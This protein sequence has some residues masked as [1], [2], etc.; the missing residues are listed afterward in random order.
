MLPED[1]ATLLCGEGDERL[2]QQEFP[3]ATAFYLAAFSCCGPTAV[4]RVSSMARGLWEQVVATLEAWCKGK[5]QIPKIQ[6]R[7]LAVVSLSVGI[8]AIFLS[9]LIPNNVVALVYKLEALLQRGC[10]E[11]VVS[12]CNLLLEANPRG[13]MELLLLRALA[14]VLSGTQVG[15]GIMDYVQA[16]VLHQT[17]AVAYVYD[18]QREHLPQVIQA[19]SDHLSTCQEESPG[20]RSSEQWLGDCYSFLAAVAPGHTWVCR[21][22]AAHLLK[23]GEFQECVTVCTKA[24]EGFSA[25]NLRGEDVLVLHLERAAGYFFLGGWMQEMMQD[26]A[27]AFAADPARAMKCFEE[28]FSPCEVEKIE[29][30]ARAALEGKFAAYRKAVRARAELRGSHGTELLPPV[31]QTIQLL[32]HICPA[33][34]R[35]LSVRLADCHLLQG[36]PRAALDMCEQLLTAEQNTYH[37]TLLALRGFC[38]LHAQDHHRALQDFQRVIEHDSPHP[39]SCI[40][41]LCGR[42]LIRISGGSNYLTALD[43]ITAC[44]LKLEETIFTIKS[45]VPWN[46]RGLLLKVL[47]EEGQMMLQKKRDAPG[48]FQLA[49]LLVELDSSDEASQILCA[50]A[51]YQMGRGEEAHK[52]LSL[53]LSRNPQRAPVLARLALL[54]LKRGFVYNGNQLLKRLIRIGDSSCL[55]PILDIFQDEDRKLLQSHCHWRAQAILKGKQGGAAIKEAIA[56]L[57]FAILAAGGYA[58]DCLLT[59]ARCYECLG[60]MKT[61]IFDF[62]AVLKKEPRNVQ[63]LSGRG[64]I[65]LALRQQKEAVQDLISA[66]KVE[67]GAVIPAILSLKPE[68]QVLVTEWVLQHGRATLTKLLATKDLS[69]EETLRDLLTMAKALTKICRTA[70]HIFYTD[71]LMANGKHQEALK[72]LQEAFGHCPAEDFARARLAVLQL[73]NRNVAGAAAPLSVLAR[74]DEKDLAFLLN[75]V[76]T[77]QQQHLAQAAA[78]EGKVLMKGHH[79]EQ[80]LGYHSLA[81]LASQDS[82]RYLRRRAAC[83]THLKKYEKALKDMEK[84]IQ[85]HGCNSPKTRAGDHCCQGFLL[86]ALAQ[87]EAAVQHYIEALQL[88]EP[89]ALDTITDCPGRESLTKTFH[90]IA[91]FNFE[92]QCYE[93][94][95]KITDYGLKIDKSAELRKLKARLKIEASSC[96]IH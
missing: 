89:L 42:G 25:E 62:N 8:A 27:A 24:L 93:E 41:A 12:K 71:V 87:E 11:E 45:Y 6:S 18:R 9:T 73:Q 67:A 85:G 7:N 35:E 54:Q 61:A 21:A 75:F 20:C 70:H 40:K 34:S 68:A 10:S 69:R 30:Q 49:S 94:A 95:W 44:Q 43:Y 15:K 80:A 23:T 58:E 26:L 83:L 53:S 48:V 77:K 28:L 2:S 55:L 86:L 3:A 76:D 33:S 50:D 57:S 13:S 59:R 56:H 74:R 31:I 46:Q 1:L 82:P 19:F 39:N 52:M 22:Q 60:Q 72:H 66:L 96:S 32:L 37:N 65:H 88:D 63:A 14:R 90:K 64:F 17:E 51:L 36:Y 16:F 91:Q 84:V 29:K 4:Q 92:K 79:H 5:C 38:S 47:Q 81:V 78:Q